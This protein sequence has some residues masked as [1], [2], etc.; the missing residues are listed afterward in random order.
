[1][2]Q[3]RERDSCNPL[4]FSAGQLA[5]RLLYLCAKLADETTGEQERFT[6]DRRTPMA[7]TLNFMALL[8]ATL[9]ATGVALLLDWLM[10]R[11]AF[12]LMRPAA[13]RAVGWSRQSELARGTQ[14]LVQ[15]YEMRRPA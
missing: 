11:A 3:S 10:L 15:A 12:Y 9:L 1:L 14:Q 2:E 7:A 8:M 5:C 6:G 4:V 13:V